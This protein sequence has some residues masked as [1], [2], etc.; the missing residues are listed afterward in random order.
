M[1]DALVVLIAAQA[2]TAAV[3]LVLAGTGEALAQRA[4]VLNVGIE[5]LLL[6]GCIA[7]YAGA[8]LSGCAWCGLAAALI[9]GGLLAALFAWATVVMRLDQIVVGMAI[10]LIAIGGSGTAW[11]VLQGGGY[12]ALTAEAGFSRGVVPFIGPQTQAWLAGLPLVG[13]LVFD[14]YALAVATAVLAVLARWLLRSTRIGLVIQALGDAPDACAANGIG[15]RRW[16]FA[17]VV[18]AGLLAGAAGAY[19]SIMRTHGFNPLMT[20]GMGFVILALVIFGR[21]RIGLLALACLGFG[22]IDAL[23]SHLQSRG[24]NAV[25]PYQVFQAAPFIVALMALACMRRGT[26]GPRMLGIPW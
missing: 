20:G 26:S 3:P 17:L 11:L 21:W 7:G 14:Q 12:E 15:V 1:N 13:P 8:V 5:G 6:A 22:L 10:N 23:Q 19:L 24:L 25:V 16:R 9:A 4:G 18:L 2:I